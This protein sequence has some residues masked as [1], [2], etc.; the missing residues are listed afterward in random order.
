VK[1][2]AQ[3]A[4]P[5]AV[6]DQFI[7]MFQKMETAVK[8]NPEASAIVKKIITLIGNLKQLLMKRGEPEEA[9]TPKPEPTKAEIGKNIREDL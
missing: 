1:P 5:E 8:S 6:L 2:E 7:S 3:K 9:A 4:T